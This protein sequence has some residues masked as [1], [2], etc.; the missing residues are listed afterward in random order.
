MHPIVVIDLVHC[1]CCIFCDADNE[2]VYSTWNVLHPRSPAM[3]SFYQRPKNRL[4]LFSYKNSWNDLESRPRSL[5]M[6]QFKV[7]CHFLLVVCTN[8]VTISYH[9]WNTQRQIIVK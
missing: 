6:A 3:S 9:F 1:I 2:T 4:H 5:A 7:T 8:H